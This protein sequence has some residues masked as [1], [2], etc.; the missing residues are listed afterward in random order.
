MGATD[1]VGATPTVLLA[2]AAF[3]GLRRVLLRSFGWRSCP[4][5]RVKADKSMPTQGVA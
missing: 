2:A 4:I 1:V 5:T 3:P